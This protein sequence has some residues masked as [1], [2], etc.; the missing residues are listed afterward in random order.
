VGS[1]IAVT[2][3]GGTADQQRHVLPRDWEG[4]EYRIPFI[5]PTSAAWGADPA[6][7]HI[8]YDAYDI[9]RIHSTSG[10]RFFIGVVRARAR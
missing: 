9:I 3:L 6:Q 5:E 10:E 2:F 7:A 8:G 4:R 1:S